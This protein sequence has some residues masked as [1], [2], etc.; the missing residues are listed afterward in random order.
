[1]KKYFLLALSLMFLAS[2][3]GCQAK[4][5]EPKVLI[6][7]NMGKI[8][9]KLYNDTPKHRDN[10]L[11]LVK[12]NYYDSVLFHRVIKEFMIQAGDPKSKTAQ[13]YDML[14][15]GGPGYTIPAEIVPGRFHKRGALAAA[16]LG[17]EANPKK[18]SS[19]SQFYIV[20]GRKYSE[21]ELQQVEKQVD[22]KDASAA[23]REYL[24]DAAHKAE[25][26]L[27]M[28]YQMERNGV[29]LD[30]LATSILDKLRKEGKLPPAFK[31]GAEQRKLYT[32]LGG[33]PF[34]DNAYTVFGEVIE[35][36]DVVDKIAAVATQTGDRP[37]ENVVILKMEIVK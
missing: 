10:F 31:Y 15:D 28:K 2:Y 4:D 14:G 5:T 37:V 18:E 6:T 26:D 12:E 36:M 33:V 16:R 27:V 9:I 23:I 25:L 20:Q 24:N 11:K 30:S 19:G 17:D 35:G 8:K 22:M 29:A 21:E 34:L 1:M 7:T 13:Q 3:P 32:T